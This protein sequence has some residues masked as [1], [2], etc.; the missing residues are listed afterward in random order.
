MLR[1]LL[2]RYA[3]H[4]VILLLL[5]DSLYVSHLIIFGARFQNVR[6]LLMKTTL[7]ITDGIEQQADLKLGPTDSIPLEPGK[8]YYYTSLCYLLLKSSIF[9]HVCSIGVA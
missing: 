2:T 7:S 6:I 5:T 9:M 3:I 8:Q 1:V 4:S